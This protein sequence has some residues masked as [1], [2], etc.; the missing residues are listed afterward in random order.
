[1][2]ESSR[3]VQWPAARA[4]QYH[5]ADIRLERRAAT[6][7]MGM[8]CSPNGRPVGDGGRGIYRTV[9]RKSIPA[10]KKFAGPGPRI[11]TII[12][13]KGPLEVRGPYAAACR[14][15]AHKQATASTDLAEP[16]LS[17]CEKRVQLINTC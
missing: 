16:A 4:T 13:R 15:G 11:G 1:M 10:K 7:G 6:M 14:G 2:D 8:V 9:A 3:R 17:V 12:K 5:D